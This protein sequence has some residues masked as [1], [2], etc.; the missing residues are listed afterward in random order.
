[1]ATGR[2][3]FPNQIDD[4]LALLGSFRGLLDAGT[5]HVDDAV[6]IAA[7]TAIADSVGREEFDVD[8]I[9]PGVFDAT[10]APAVAAVAE[11]QPAARG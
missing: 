2:S 6:L 3:D 4:V 1:M 7:A 9:V 8:D 10:V 11:A 5:R